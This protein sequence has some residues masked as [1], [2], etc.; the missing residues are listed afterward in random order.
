MGEFVI[1]TTAYNPS[2]QNVITFDITGQN[3]HGFFYKLASDI[4]DPVADITIT[5]VGGDVTSA[6]LPLELSSTR[7]ISN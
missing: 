5:W 3:G 2:E 4:T 6:W 7:Y 1:S